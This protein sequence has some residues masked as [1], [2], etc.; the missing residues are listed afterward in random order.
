MRFIGLVVCVGLLAAC[1]SASVPYEDSPYAL[2][3]SG[4]RLVLERD[5]TIPAG[6][7][8]LYIQGGEVRPYLEVDFY[9]PHCR[10]E[11]E[12][13]LDIPQVVKRDTFLIDKVVTEQLP[14]PAAGRR[15]LPRWP[16]AA[17]AAPGAGLVLASTGPALAMERNPRA[18]FFGQHDGPSHWTFITHLRL[19]SER[20]PQVRQLSCQHWDDPALGV[21]LTI[22]QIRETLRGIFALELR[23]GGGANG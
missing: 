9:R 23:P 16:V 12:K 11:V 8:S 4:S 3:P 17:A 15:A 13:V 22:R 14:W 21:P 18:G 2:I 20:Q 5:L 7:A 1:Q 10:L 19:R 6:R